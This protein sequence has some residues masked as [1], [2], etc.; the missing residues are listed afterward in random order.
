MHVH[1]SEKRNLDLVAQVVMCNERMLGI[2]KR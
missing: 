2:M 1:V